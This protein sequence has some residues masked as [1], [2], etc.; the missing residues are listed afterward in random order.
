MKR[1]SKEIKIG[2]I[3]IG[4][5]NKIAVQSMLNTSPYDLEKSL[6]QAKELKNAKCDILRIAIPDRKSV[7]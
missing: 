3:K 4:G 2:N 5:N 6:F 7:V 1:N